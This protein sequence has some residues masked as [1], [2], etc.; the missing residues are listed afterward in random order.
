[1]KQNLRIG[2]FKN[3]A[4]KL[5]LIHRKGHGSDQGDSGGISYSLCILAFSCKIHT[6]YSYRFRIYD[7]LLTL[8]PAVYIRHGAA[9][10]VGV[11]SYGTYDRRGQSITSVYTNVVAL[12]K[13]LKETIYERRGIS[14]TYSMIVIP[15]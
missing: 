7:S 4:N 15:Q 2:E 8:G 3:G 13:W 5:M 11:C 14:F 12:K 9:I 1:M 10:L 6:P